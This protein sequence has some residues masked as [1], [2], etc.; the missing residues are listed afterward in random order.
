M[1]KMYFSF[2]VLLLSV[3]SIAQTLPLTFE[4]AGPFPWLDD[5]NVVTTVIDNPQKSGINTSDKVV[6]TIKGPGGQPWAGTVFTLPAPIDYSSQTSMRMKVFS[7][8]PGT[9]VL[10]KVENISITSQNF[11][12][13]VLTTATNAW[14]DLTFN[15]S[16]IITTNTYQKIIVIFQL[17]TVGTGGADFTFLFDDIR[18]ENQPPGSLTLPVVPIDFESPTVDYTFGNFGGG[19]TTIIDNPQKVGINVSN[20][21]AR[22]VK[23]P[24][25]VYGGS[26][27]TLGQPLNFST[28]K[29]FRMKVFS[30]RVGAKVLFK[31]E[32]A[33]PNVERE[34]LT[35][36]ANEWEDMTF[37]FAGIS[38]VLQYNKITLIFDNGTNGDGSANFTF[39]MDDIRQEA[40]GSSGGTQMNL[41][42]TFD[43]P[44]V[45]YGL[46]GFGNTVA[47]II[48]VTDP[49]AF[50]APTKVAKVIKPANAPEWAGTT[51]SSPDESG[52]SSKIPFAP[53]TTTMYVKV[54]SP[55]AGIKVRLKAE[56]AYVPSQSV[57]TDATTTVAGG[58]ENLL[59]DFSNHA[60]GT[61]AINFAFNYNKLSIFMN[62]GVTGAVAGEK[63]YYFDNVQMNSVNPPLPVKLLAFTAEKQDKTVML[64]WSTAF[65]I[66]NKGFDVERNT[67]GNKWSVIA[68]VPGTGNHNSIRNYEI[69][70][71]MPH[72]GLN[73]YRI[74][75][76]DFDGKITYSAIRSIDFAGVDITDLKVYPNPTTDRL[77][78][79]SNAFE[80]RVN[81]SVLSA[82]GTV[83]SSG[84][85]ANTD[86]PTSIN[87]SNLPAGVYFLQLKGDKTSRTTKFVVQ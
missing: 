12:K 55:D 69:K 13:E 51:I 70:D 76:T 19:A 11:E 61:A 48:T 29:I 45:N 42:V 60:S 38:T 30:P 5:A 4:G 46:I 14:E 86:N 7:K 57:E 49:L 85:I 32:G 18:Q 50:P 65:E 43:E 25:Q 40:G 3:C 36:K 28:D 82:M 78:I 15:F 52:F 56:V 72:S 10:L 37:N 9:K 77:M 83:L 24:D 67:D 87:V 68:T 73:Q 6:Q 17:G 79:H 27:L 26:I 21:V 23:N 64:K 31:L 41:P 74:R 80:G 33:I 59:F 66:N 54:W 2:F 62:F 35:T 71:L 16:G 20:K 63:I 1:K 47:S 84:I 44:G 58:W 53:G 34:V 39:L 75:Q 81:Y 22:M 8:A